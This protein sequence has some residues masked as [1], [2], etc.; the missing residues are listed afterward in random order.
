M[1]HGVEGCQPQSDVVID[2]RPFFL[3]HHL[4]SSWLSS[5]LYALFLSVSWGMRCFAV[6][7]LPAADVFTPV[8]QWFTMY[9]EAG[10][11]VIKI[12]TTAATTTQSKIVA[13]SLILNVYTC[14]SFFHSIANV[15]C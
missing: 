11:E 7:F 15:L 1:I 13:P 4:N 9:C 5:L 6:S 10:F 8:C 14:I 3:L 2:S 12:S